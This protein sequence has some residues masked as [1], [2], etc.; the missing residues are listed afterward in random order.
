MHIPA[1]PGPSNCGRNPSGPLIIL[2][3]A[4]ELNPTGCW[5]TS[6]AGFGWDGALCSLVR[7]EMKT[8]GQLGRRDEAGQKPGQKS[9]HGVLLSRSGACTGE[10]V[11]RVE[12]G[13]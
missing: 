11:P 8:G 3:S 5:H 4:Q 13:M 7:R 2:S 6:V 9:G 12:T 1:L 10:S